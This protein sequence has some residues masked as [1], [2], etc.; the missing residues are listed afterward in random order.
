MIYVATFV[1]G[2]LVGAV[3]HEFAANVL[4]LPYGLILI[5][6]AGLGW[7]VDHFMRKVT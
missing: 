3:W 1:I 5:G 6:A 2:C 4:H 7:G